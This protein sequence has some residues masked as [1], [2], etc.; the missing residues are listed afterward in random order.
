[1]RNRACVWLLAVSLA[2]GCASSMLAPEKARQAEFLEK[3]TVKRATAYTRAL[4]WF[5][6]NL[7]YR[8][9]AP[10]TQDST[11]GKMKLEGGYRCNVLRKPNDLKEYFVAFEL[12]Y[13]TPPGA[14]GL[15]FTQLRMEDADGNLLSRPEY[16]LGTTENVD[17]VQPCLK[18]MVAAL[19]KA[20]E[21][22]TL[23][24]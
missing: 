10:R 14:I 21:S 8:S 12:D 17:R 9:G 19:L 13:D 24:W 15:H 22:T 7:N 16:Q 20:V 23:T 3:T 5:D 18:K 11:A 1:M 4:R 6:K 2:V